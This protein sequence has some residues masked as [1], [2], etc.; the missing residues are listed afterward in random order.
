MTDET[1]LS[2]LQA[3]PGWAAQADRAGL[4]DTGVAQ[5]LDEARKLA[6]AV[7]DPLAGVADAE[8]CRIESGRVKTPAGY[9]ETYRRFGADGWICADLDPDFGGMGLPLALH[10]AASLPF[11]GAAMPFMM[12]LGSSRAGAH[13]L[14]ELAPDL[15]D[16]WCP[17]LAAGDWAVTICI[18]EPDAGSD[19]GRIRTK[20]VK[21]G[22]T[23]R[24]SG[25]KCWISFGDHDMTDR[26]GHLALARTGTPE[27]G[28]RGLSLFLV[29]NITDDGAD[30]GIRV[31]RIEEKLGLHGSPTCV[32]RFEDSLG[33]MIGAPGRGLAQLFTMIE[34][35]RLQVGGQGAGIILRCAALAR[36]YAEDRKQGGSPKS[37]PVPI[38]SHPDVQRQLLAIDAQAAVTTAL[39]FEAAVAVEEGRTDAGMQ[40]YAAF[41]LP[42]AKT[43]CGEGA[44][45][46]TS[47]T[48]QVLGG[49]GYTR[50]WS[51]ERLFR[52][53]RICTIYEGTTGMQ[54]QDFLFRRLLKDQ[55]AGLKALGDRMRGELGEGPG[56]DLLAQFEALSERLAKASASAQLAA[57][58]GYLR[59]GWAAVSACLAQRVAGLGGE[60]AAA[61][62]Y[63][64]A[65]AP[66][67][68][69]M[70]EAQV[71][72]ALA[73][74]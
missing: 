56:I 34:L 18:S 21:D 53:A 23:W 7:L 43:F 32:M 65:L 47:A 52:D 36:A 68:F 48:I 33:T 57:A 58:D 64:L 1:I 39:M 15:R 28:T 22:G 59:A 30:N 38:I 24:L 46:A 6:E 3:T 5:I 44:Q 4:D 25:T 16:V 10:V 51:A 42:L 20:A 61:A 19:V 54:G 72:Y 60:R 67:R 27:E 13:L 73:K 12:A 31:E 8:H 41:L 17:R 9:P 11:E 69:G 45:E 40:A 49:A 35:M 70:A 55:G 71:T 66:A 2:L 62:D 63:W 26:I 29:P 74:G 50:E 14:A 37:P